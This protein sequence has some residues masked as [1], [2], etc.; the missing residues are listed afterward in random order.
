MTHPEG[1]VETLI[2]D[3]TVLSLACADIN[4][5]AASD[6]IRFIDVFEQRTVIIQITLFWMPTEIKG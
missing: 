2:I 3:M 4:K 5:I 1:G 6:L